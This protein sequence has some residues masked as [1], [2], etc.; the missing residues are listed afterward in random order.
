MLFYKQS[1]SREEPFVMLRYA[2]LIVFS[3]T[4]LLDILD[5]WLAR[6][7]G[8]MTQLGAILDPLADKALLLSAFI[9]IAG[10][11][12]GA[13]VPAIPIWFVALVISRD[14]FIMTGAVLVKMLSGRVTIVPRF[15]GKASTVFQTF[16]IILV[17]LDL[18]VIPTYA[19]LLG[20]TCCTVISGMQYIFDGYRQLGKT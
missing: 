17:L 10:N 12:S 7:R 13:F 8:E 3:L 6:K 5:G 11:S 20:A 1:S 16:T 9:L 4:L 19:A 18:G 15:F 14:F 2:A